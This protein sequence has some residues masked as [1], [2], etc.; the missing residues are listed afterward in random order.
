MVAPHA[1]KPGWIYHHSQFYRDRSGSLKG[2]YFIVVA[3]SNSDEV[4]A[5]VLTSKATGRR[6]DPHASTEHPTPHIIWA[7]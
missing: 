6:K 1:I 5:R 2:K 3:I 7:I 4:V